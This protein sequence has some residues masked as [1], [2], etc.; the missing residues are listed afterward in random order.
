MK[1]RRKDL[2][3]LEGSIFLR[4]EDAELVRIEGR[5]SKSP[6]F[7]TR[8]VEIV[9]RFQRFAGVRMPIT[10][11]SSANVFI[12]GRSTFRMTYEYETVNGQSVGDP[13]PRTP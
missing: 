3:L 5:P 1:P 11:E 10:F 12:A 9:R 2:L 7:W 13:R 6:S 8:Q 4:P